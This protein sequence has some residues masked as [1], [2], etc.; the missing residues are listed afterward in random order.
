MISPRRHRHR[1]P[2]ARPDL[3]LRSTPRSASAGPTAR[4]ASS[5]RALELQRAVAEA[6]DEIA[7][8]ASDRVVVID[9]DGTVEEVHERVMAAV[10]AR[11][12]RDALRLTATEHQPS[13]GAGW[14]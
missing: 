8:I 7:Q 14:R 1:R 2:L 11:R 9:A 10:D 5:P 4:T 13:R 3:L 12:M 6:Y